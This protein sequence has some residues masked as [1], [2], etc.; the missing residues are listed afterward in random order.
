MG[1]PRQEVWLGRRF[2]DLDVPVAVAIG[3]LFD[4]FA[5]TSATPPRWMGRIGLEWLGRLAADPRRLGHRYLVE[6]VLLGA[7]LVRERLR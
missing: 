6:P 3:G 1:M 4:Y 5:G 7:D 2:D